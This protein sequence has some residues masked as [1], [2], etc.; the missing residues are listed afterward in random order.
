MPLRDGHHFVDLETRC[1]RQR[2]EPH[3]RRPDSSAPADVESGS[4][5][6]GDRAP[7]DDLDFAVEQYFPSSQHTARR[8]R[9]AVDQLDRDVVGNPL[10]AVQ[11][12][13]G[14]TRDRPSTPRPQP[15][16]DGALLQRRLQGF[17][18]VHIRKHRAVIG[19]QLVPGQ[20]SGGQ[21]LATD[22]WF[23]RIAHAG[24]SHTAGT[25]SAFGCPQGGPSMCAPGVGCAGWEEKGLRY[26]HT[27]TGKPLNR[28]SAK[29]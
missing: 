21:G 17:R 24:Q 9:I 27:C 19:P 11:R 22:T 12:C 5:R 20:P 15:C 25:S 28:H 26:R 8:P 10:R 2:V 23:W 4:L 16:R 1:A 14:R 6:C 29:T 3:H 13:R 18:Q 7:V